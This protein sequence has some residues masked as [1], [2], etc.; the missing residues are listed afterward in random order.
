M[1]KGKVNI[2]PYGDNFDNF[3]SRD[4]D[5]WS[6]LIQL[7]DAKLEPKI[8]FTGIRVI[9]FRNNTETVYL[10]ECIVANEVNLISYGVSLINDLSVTLNNDENKPTSIKSF[11]RISASNS[12]CVFTLSRFSS[13]GKIVGDLVSQVIDT[14]N[15]LAR[16]GIIQ[17]INLA[18]SINSNKNDDLTEDLKCYFL[19]PYGWNLPT[20]KSTV[21]SVNNDD[22]ANHT[23]GQKLVPKLDNVK[24]DKR[25]GVLYGVIV[26]TTNIDPVYF[27]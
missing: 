25:N 11:S 9:P 23:T 16:I 3:T 7:F 19:A 5:D 4:G 21:I 8:V 6:G 10:S 27:E 26:P 17:G 15:N 1:P 14:N 2:F 18:I 13:R 12:S 24:L 22:F 20:D